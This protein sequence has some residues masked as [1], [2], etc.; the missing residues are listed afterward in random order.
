[1][2]YHHNPDED[3]WPI[4][5]P[6]LSRRIEGLLKDQ[7]VEDFRAMDARSSRASICELEVSPDYSLAIR[8]TPNGTHFVN[9][10][11]QCASMRAGFAGDCLTPGPHAS[12]L[13]R[14]SCR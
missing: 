8:L 3:S 9:F 4:G 11:P 7:S 10:E 6:L 14:V 2:F 12:A 1:M 13:R 5:N